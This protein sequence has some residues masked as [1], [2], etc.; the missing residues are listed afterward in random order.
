[1]ASAPAVNQGNFPYP[2]GNFAAPSQPPTYAQ[3]NFPSPGEV[4]HGEFYPEKVPVPDPEL[5]I[6]DN[7]EN[8]LY[9]KHL[10]LSQHGKTPDEFQKIICCCLLKVAQVPHN[11]PMALGVPDLP[12]TF[13]RTILKNKFRKVDAVLHLCLTP[14]TPH[15]CVTLPKLRDSTWIDIVSHYTKY[16]LISDTNEAPRYIRGNVMGENSNLKQTVESII[17]VLSTDNPY[18]LTTSASNLLRKDIDVL[19]CRFY[20]ICEQLVTTDVTAELLCADPKGFER[21]IAYLENFLKFLLRLHTNQTRGVTGFSGL[22]SDHLKVLL[23]GAVVLSQGLSKS[24]PVGRLVIYPE[25]DCLR[26]AEKSLTDPV[27][28]QH[29]FTFDCFS[30][31]RFVVDLTPQIPHGSYGL[32]R[33]LENFLVRHQN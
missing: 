8:A 14:P 21:I 10:E 22:T 12:L 7:D 31:V 13:H 26:M 33:I 5:P 23:A 17:E 19:V 25:R 4:Q 11:A 3:Y 1:M 16:V 28:K 32:L 24:R 30:L 18:F 9:L 2:Q 29:G 27:F 15:E 6:D 20:A